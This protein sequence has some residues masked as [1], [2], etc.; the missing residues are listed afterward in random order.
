MCV[1]TRN[2]H[3]YCTAFNAL[4]TEKTMKVI[5]CRKH[6]GGLFIYNKSDYTA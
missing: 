2:S 3:T 6:L 5:N 4:N 1:P